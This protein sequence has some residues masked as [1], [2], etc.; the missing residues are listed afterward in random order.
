M[1]RTGDVRR[2]KPKEFEIAYRTVKG[3]EPDEWFVAATCRLTPG[4]KQV[5]L[6]RIKTLLERR[7]LTQ[8]TS[9]Y[10]CGSVFRN[11]PDDHAARLIESCDLKGFMIGGAKVSQKHAN[12]IINHE[13]RASA[14][15]IEALISHV[16]KTILDKTGI[17]LIREVHILGEN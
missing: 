13:G 16:H 12:F 3:L 8:P 9:E 11:P 10:N 15:D 14:A 6:G 7:A 4:D 2:R 5:A 1:T 17:D